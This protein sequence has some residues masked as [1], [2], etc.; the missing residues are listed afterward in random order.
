MNKT[1]EVIPEMNILY[2]ATETE[3]SGERLQRVIE[4]LVPEE[5]R[6]VYRTIDSLSSRLCQPKDYYLTIAVL[7]AASRK[8]LADILSIH[9]LLCDI[10]IIL[11]LPDRENDTIAWGH[12]LQPRYL[13]YIDS[14]FTDVAAVLG[15]MMRQCIFTKQR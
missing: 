7:L 15:K 6:E 2:Y 10:R 5:T 11:I 1:K 4:T 12:S 9:D 3:G 14:D 8:D 13:S